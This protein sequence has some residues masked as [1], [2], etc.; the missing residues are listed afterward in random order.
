MNNQDRQTVS[1]ADLVIDDLSGQ[2]AA[3]AREL[4]VRNA[5]ITQLESFIRANAS[6]LGLTQSPDG[7]LIVEDTAQAPSMSA[8]GAPNPRTNGRRA[9]KTDA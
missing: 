2:V 4:A 8:S 5:R 7:D 3:Q 1:M 9:S 6:V